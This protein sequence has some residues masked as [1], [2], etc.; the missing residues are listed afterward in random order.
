MSSTRTV[1]IT[2]TL[3]ASHGRGVLQ[4]RARSLEHT[5]S[6]CP[7]ESRRGVFADSHVCDLQTR[8]GTEA[9]ATHIAM[10][11]AA[12]LANLK[13]DIKN[14]NPEWCLRKCNEIEPCS[15]MF[16]GSDEPRTGVIAQQGGP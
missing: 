14:L 2:F 3:R 9:H 11:D 12:R 10:I 7:L 6:E 15:Y 1:N 13:R 8:I 4:D 16:N 5:A